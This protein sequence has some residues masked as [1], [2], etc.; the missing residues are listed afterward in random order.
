MLFSDASSHSH[1][2]VSEAGDDSER[3]RLY[4]ETQLRV[5]GEDG[6]VVGHF[7]AQPIEVA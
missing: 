4:A 3:S 6:A 7:P 5:H 2:R 1:T